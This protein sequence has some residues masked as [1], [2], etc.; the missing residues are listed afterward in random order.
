LG[1]P[2]GR[3]STRHQ[4]PHTLWQ[5]EQKFDYQQKKEVKYRKGGTQQLKQAQLLTQSAATRHIRIAEGT[6]GTDQELKTLSTQI[7]ET[8][9]ETLSHLSCRSMSKVILYQK[10]P[11]QRLWQN[12]HIYTQHSQTQGIQESICI[13][14]HYKD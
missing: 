11:K 6:A 10:H 1:F 7:G 13:E 5:I 9:L 2:V 14:Q 3:S 12:K 8:S 4:T